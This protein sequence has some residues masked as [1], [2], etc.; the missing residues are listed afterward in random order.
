MLYYIVITL[1]ELLEV[2]VV[3]VVLFDFC[4]FVVVVVCFVFL[5][6]FGVFFCVFF[7]FLGGGGGG[8]FSQDVFTLFLNFLYSGGKNSVF[9]LSLSLPLFPYVFV[10]PWW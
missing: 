9:S 10:K 7:F 5:L 3:V 4:V 2:A 8:L 1:Y 6:F